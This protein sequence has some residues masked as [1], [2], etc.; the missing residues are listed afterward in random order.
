MGFKSKHKGKTAFKMMLINCKKNF[1][2]FFFIRYFLHLHFKCYPQ[3]SL[4][5]PRSLL[6][7]QPTPDSWPWHSP[8]LGHMI[9]C[10]TKGLSSHWWLTSPSSATN[11]TRNT[12]LRGGL[13]V[14]SYCC[15]SY[16]V[17]DPFSSLGTFSSSFIRG[18][19][20][21]PIADCEHP[22]L[23]L[24]IILFIYMPKQKSI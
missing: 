15:S 14:N 6:P 11:A 1:F 12:A 7:N 24:Q 5:P 20:I 22:L 17:A 10:K 13:L 19:V 8:V 9:F 3:S 16:R 18:P 21:H 2:I 4:Y 23:Y